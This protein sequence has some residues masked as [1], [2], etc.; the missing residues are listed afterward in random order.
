MIPVNSVQGLCFFPRRL[1][2]RARVRNPIAGPG[3]LTKSTNRQ[4]SCDRVRGDGRTNQGREDNAR[5][6]EN[7]KACA[8]SHACN[9]GCERLGSVKLLSNEKTTDAALL[10]MAAMLCGWLL[11]C[12][13]KPISECRYLL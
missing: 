12:L 9:Q 13:A 7:N 5:L 8:S 10:A 6:D 2:S 11:Y 3:H 1:A 4:T